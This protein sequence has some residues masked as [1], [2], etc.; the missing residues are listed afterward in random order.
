[1]QNINRIIRHTISKDLYYDIDI[2]NAFPC[3]LHQYLEKNRFPCPKLA[4]YANNRDQI[5][6]DLIIE[7]NNKYNKDYLKKAFLTII[8]GGN[9]Y[10]ITDYQFVDDFNNEIQLIHNFIYLKIPDIEED[11]ENKQNKKN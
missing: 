9:N 11:E 3:I 8:H 1:M 2:K 7:S 5:I 4:E 6:N 10:L